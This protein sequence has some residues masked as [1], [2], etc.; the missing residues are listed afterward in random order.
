[1][2]RAHSL[3]H[4]YYTI[5]YQTHLQMKSLIIPTILLFIA[6][7]GLGEFHIQWW[8]FRLRLEKPYQL[9]GILFV[10]IGLILFKTQAQKDTKKAIIEQMQREVEIE[11]LKS[12][13]SI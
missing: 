7:W 2:A 12:I 8:P 11:I 10:V 5:N 13:K 6:L 4:H 3:H 1:M 9:L